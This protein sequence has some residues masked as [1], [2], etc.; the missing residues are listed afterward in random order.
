MGTDPRRTLQEAATRRVSCE[1]LSRDGSCAQG[2][3]VRVERGGIVLTTASRRFA[4]GEDV[5][6]WLS[7]DG[8]PYTFE[9]SVIRTGVP[10]PDRTQDGLLIGFIDRWTEGTAG[11]AGED[12]I[13]EVLPPNGPPISLLLPPAQLVEVT[14]SGLSFVVPLAFK[15]VFVESGAQ[16]VR[17]GIAGV[18][19]QE[20]S[21]HVRA[22]AQGEDYLLY[23]LQIDEIPDPDVYRIIIDGL[24]R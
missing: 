15:L 8:Q 14:L 13:V 4:G 23:H 19:V 10:V 17:L 16:Q 20:V 11:A 3:V 9:A 1:I 7:M 5:R 12:R 6:I 18:P 21:A 22:L 24:A 2:T